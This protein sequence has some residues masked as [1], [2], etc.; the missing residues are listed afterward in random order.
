MKTVY[1][2]RSTKDKK[3][4]KIGYTSLKDGVFNRCDSFNKM[5]KG[6]KYKKYSPFV[7]EAEYAAPNGM[8]DERNIHYYA[9]EFRIKGTELF[10]D[11]AL[12]ILDQY[13]KKAKLGKAVHRKDD[14]EN[15]KFKK[16]INT[17]KKNYLIANFFYGFKK[18]EISDILKPYGYFGKTKLNLGTYCFSEIDVD[19]YFDAACGFN[20]D[21]GYKPEMNGCFASAKEEH[22]YFIFGKKAGDQ[23]KRANKQGRISTIELSLAVGR[24]NEEQYKEELKKVV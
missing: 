7:V 1:V 20:R 19:S 4:I 2:L 14:R 11:K 9:K 17:L 21:M 18:G 5:P 23:R 10:S 8:E 16:G 12:P 24:I 13:V 22:I 15:I 3:V 6:N